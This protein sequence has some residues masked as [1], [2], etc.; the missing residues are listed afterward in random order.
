MSLGGVF[1]IAF[2]LSCRSFRVLALSLAFGVI[3]AF[4][5]SS[6]VRRIGVP[7]SLLPAMTQLASTLT[8]VTPAARGARYELV[9]WSRR[10]WPSVTAISL[11]GWLSLLFLGA[12][13]LVYIARAVD[14]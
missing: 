11:L 2:S 1:C 4:A 6:A 14:D 13:Q 3:G 7:R 12:C 9:G 5:W 10:H 8:S